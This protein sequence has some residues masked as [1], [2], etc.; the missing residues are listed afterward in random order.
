VG[1]INYDKGTTKGLQFGSINYAGT[2]GG[3]QFAVINYAEEMHGL[4]VGG[5]N[6]IKK[7]GMFPFMI[8]A[9]WGKK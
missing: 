6:I 5:I 9:N 1:L 2:G 7:G 8:L 4:Q 3:L